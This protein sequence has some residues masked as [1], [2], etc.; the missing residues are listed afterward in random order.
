MIKN[1]FS[2][3]ILLSLVAGLAACE[4]M[5]GKK[6]ETTEAKTGSDAIVLSAVSFSDLP[7]WTADRQKEAW[8]ALQ[9]SCDKFLALPPDR[10]I[11]SPA[12]EMTAGDWHGACGEI[13]AADGLPDDAVRALL[14]EHF[15]IYAAS[16]TSDGDEG[17]F[18][19]YFEA[20]LK[21]AKQASET[22]PYPLYARPD[23]LVSVDFGKFSKDLNGRQAIGQVYEGRVRPYPKRGDIEGGLLAGKGLEIAWAKDA[24]DLFLLQV[25]GSGRLIL[26]DGSVM[27]VG[28]AA[29]NGHPYKSIGRHLIDL[30]E[31]KPHE[32]SWDGIRKWLDAHPDKHHELFAVNPRFI[33][34][35]ELKGDGPIGSQGVALTPGRSLAVDKRFIPMGVPV[36]LDTVWPSEHDKPL[37]RLMVAQ[38]TGGAIKG[39]VRG[40]FFW[41]YGADALKYA[42]KMKSPGRYYLLLPKSL[43]GRIETLGS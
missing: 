17:L 40:D 25:Q 3:L 6:A 38:D 9:R 26:D 29:H 34:F 11:G 22:Y 31:L 7:D 2:G 18:T 5:P 35:R 10:K 16:S 14:E 13:S 15:D 23:D 41:G 43:A 12:I 33:F 28:F 37:R 19:G 30:G 8:P 27:R 24:V 36:W 32:A 42:G 20:E 21:G 4:Q 39:V 1:R